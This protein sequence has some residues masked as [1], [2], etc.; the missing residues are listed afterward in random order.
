[1]FH[2]LSK[3]KRLV[4]TFYPMTFS[5]NPMTTKASAQHVAMFGVKL[6]MINVFIKGSRGGGK[7]SASKE[8]DT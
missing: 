4:T 1:M 8:T 6:Q 3:T 5:L 2:L 7:P